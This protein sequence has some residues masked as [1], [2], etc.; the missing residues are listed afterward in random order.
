MNLCEPYYVVRVL[1]HD[2]LV[3]ERAIPVV[4]KVGDYERDWAILEVSESSD[5]VFA[6]TLPLRS[7]D[8]PLPSSYERTMYLKTI[9]Y[10]VGLRQRHKADFMEATSTDYERVEH[11]YRKTVEMVNGLL[12]RVSGAPMIDQDGCVACIHVDSVREV[13]FPNKRLKLAD[14]VSEDSSSHAH[15]RFGSII[16]HI[17]ELINSLP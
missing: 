13:Y 1:E 4:Y 9:Y 14:I 5:Y 2:Q 10:K 16:F 12:K 6:E 11:V 3:D 7:A 8:R 15:S 17:P